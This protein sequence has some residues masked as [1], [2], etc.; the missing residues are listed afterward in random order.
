MGAFSWKSGV[1]VALLV[2]LPRASN[3]QQSDAQAIA[4][5]QALVDEGG[6][7]MDAGKYAAACP[8]FE[9]ATKLIPEGIGAKLELAECYE[10]IGRL[11]S[12]Q[13]QYLQAGALARAKKDERAQDAERAAARLKPQLATMRLDVPSAVQDIE[14]ITLT[15]DGRALDRGIWGTPIPVDKGKHV[16]EVK[17]PG[18]KPWKD[19][20]TVEA[21][22]RSVTQE[23]PLL[24]KQPEEKRVGGLGSEVQTWRTPLLFTG[25]GLSVV[26]IGVGVGFLLPAFAK[27]KE[28]R[29]IADELRFTRQ[30]SEELCPV[31]SK[32]PQCATLGSLQ[33]DRDTFSTLG[34]AG[35]ALGGVAAAGTVVLA[36]T[37]PSKSAAPA[38]TGFVVLPSPGGIWVK[39]TF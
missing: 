29:S 19:D 38:K 2:I 12:A 39:G 26:G 30:T 14:G 9:Q 3:A 8:K 6:A 33:T 10:K 16:I 7:L 35:F 5:A 21:N 24:E 13:G 1:V 18:W 25:I 28:A 20:V 32:D 22:G 23:V 34:I 31:A 37:G 17:A 36:L 15:W 11:A 4:A 27:D